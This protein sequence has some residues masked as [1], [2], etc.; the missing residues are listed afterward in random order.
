[1]AIDK[2]KI[3]HV[4]GKALDCQFEIYSWANMLSDCDLTQEE[5][6]WAFEHLTYCL[7][8]VN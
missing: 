7:K 1:M 6:N 5:Y 3:I 8:E 2:N 4:V